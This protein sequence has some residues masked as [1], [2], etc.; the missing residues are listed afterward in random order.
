MQSELNGFDELIRAAESFSHRSKAT[1]VATGL[2]IV[3]LIQ[4]WR[5]KIEAELRQHEHDTWE[6][7]KCR[8]LSST[9]YSQGYEAGLKVPTKHAHT[10][11]CSECVH[12]YFNS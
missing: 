9:F 8:K 5:P 2:D 6:C 3:A 11:A 4:V 1:S 10:K 7:D 12:F